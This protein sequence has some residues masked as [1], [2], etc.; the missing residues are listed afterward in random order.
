[1]AMVLGDVRFIR[2]SLGAIARGVGLAI[3]VGVLVGVFNIGNELPQEVA[4]R[5]QPGL[6]DLGVALFSG[7]A[8]AYALCYSQAAGALPGVAIAA[9]LVPPLASV[10]IAFVNG[11][12]SESLGALLLFGT[13][14]I[15]ISSASAFVFFLLGFRPTT[16][17]KQR[18]EVRL[19]TARWAIILLIVNAAIL[20]YATVSLV[21][22]ATRENSI[23]N[24]V[25]ESVRVIEGERKATID[26]YK[27]EVDNVIVVDGS[28]DENLNLKITV[29]SS[30]AVFHG[31]VESLRQKINDYL[32]NEEYEYDEIGLELIVIDVTSLDPKVLPTATAT[33]TVTKYPPL[34][35]PTPTA[36]NTPTPTRTPTAT[37]TNT[38]LPTETATIT[39]IPTETATATP[40]QTPSAT[41]TITLGTINARDGELLRIQPR[42]SAE[43][44][45]VL[46]NGSPILLQDG[47]VA[48]DGIIWQEVI[49][50]S[51]R[52]WVPATSINIQIAPLGP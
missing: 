52:G 28:N 39:P 44:I 19:R 14:F 38:P 30:H 18:L 37:A 35:G 17:E 25:T 10:G 33:P 23:Q 46:S 15:T 36:S 5:T 42:E 12:P 16:S 1:M 40:T 24:A 32:T 20:G 7:L 29:R 21:G 13:N 45:T 50:N 47:T 48:A 27:L 2:L 26:N 11:K 8:G 41:P 49:A 31:H 9:A 34:L 3:L 43:S 51:Q 22:D 4:N 6:L